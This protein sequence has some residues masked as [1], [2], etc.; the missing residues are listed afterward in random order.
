MKQWH[1]LQKHYC[2]LRKHLN[3]HVQCD[4]VSFLAVARCTTVIDLLVAPLASEL[5]LSGALAYTTRRQSGHPTA[6]LRH[7]PFGSLFTLAL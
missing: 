4:A 2:I 6:K 1:L 7:T 3:A 5:Y